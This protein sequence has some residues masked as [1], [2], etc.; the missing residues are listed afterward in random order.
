MVNWIQYEGQADGWDKQLEALGGGFY[1]SYGWGAV[2][3][4]AGWQPFRLLASSNG[5]VVAAASVLC[6]RRAGIPVC[7]IPGGPVGP[8]V[9]FDAGFRAALGRLLGSRIFYC[10]MSVLRETQ[11][12]EKE[13]LAQAGWGRPSVSMSSGLTMLYSLEGEASERLK[14]TS[15]NWRHNLK[16]S[17]HHGLRIER[18]ERPDLDELSALYREMEELKSLPVQ[19]SESEL[20][21]MLINLGERLVMYRCLDGEGKLLAV[22]AAGLFGEI[23][24]DLLAAA[25]ANARKVYAS[26]ATLWALL[27]HCSQRGLSYYD[28]SGVDPI[29]NKGVYDFKQGTGARLVECLGEWEWA[30]IPGMCMAFN[31][32]LKRRAG[33]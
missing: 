3:R 15:S 26:H 6:Q 13:S 11:P 24:W 10:R 16:R 9:H 14:R 28:L 5:Q 19:H 27:D 32:V 22:R 31:W 12:E 7:W 8:A 23:A 17:A 29:G 2:R 18:W 30:S 20:E 4:V 25:G 33:A 21:A 1:Q